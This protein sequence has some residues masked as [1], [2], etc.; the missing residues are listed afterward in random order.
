MDDAPGLVLERRAGESRTSAAFSFGHTTDRAVPSAGAP[1]DASMRLPFELG[2]PA[3]AFRVHIRNWQF[4]SEEAFPTPVTITGVY[5]GEQ[6]VGGE[7]GPS[8]VFASTST[9][10]AGTANLS[11]DGFVSD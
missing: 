6:V 3:D 7:A 10:V 4:D 11:T 8:G 5:V 9:G 1:M 2:V